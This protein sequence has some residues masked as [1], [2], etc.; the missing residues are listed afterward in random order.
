MAT[1]EDMQQANLNILQTVAEITRRSQELEVENCQLRAEIRKLQDI[2]RESGLTTKLAAEPLQGQAA[3]D[4]M[5][6]TYDREKTL[7]D[8]LYFNRFHKVSL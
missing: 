4:R 5:A 6:Y 8:G 3:I 7:L 1:D 2:I